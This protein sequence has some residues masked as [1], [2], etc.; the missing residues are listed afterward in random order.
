MSLESVDPIFGV[1]GMVSTIVGWFTPSD[2][3]KILDSI[4]AL[5]DQ[6]SALEVEMT[7]YF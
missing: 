3:K 5:S 7:Y 4:A 1:I 6:I 2:T